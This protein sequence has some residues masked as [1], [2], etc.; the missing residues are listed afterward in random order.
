VRGSSSHDSATQLLGFRAWAAAWAIAGLGEEACTA[1][2]V[3]L[4]LLVE[5]KTSRRVV[6]MNA[7]A[8]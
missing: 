8:A 3:E 7:Q 1:L 2:E 6:L 4:Y 5:A